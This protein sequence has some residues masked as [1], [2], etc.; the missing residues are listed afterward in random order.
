MKTIAIISRKGGAGKTTIVLHLAVEA[1]AQGKRV[2]VFDLDPQASAALWSDHR[3]T[4]S[5]Y[6]IPAQAPRLA[7][8]LEQ[9]KKQ[10]A[11]LVI[12]DTAPHDDGAASAAASHADFIIIPCRPSSLDLD[13]ITTSIRLASVKAKDAYVLINSAPAQGNETSQAMNA[14]EKAGVQVCPVVLHQR[15]SFSSHMQIGLTAGEFEARGKA[16]EEIRN[17]YSWIANKISI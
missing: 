2:A 17:L 7:S 4:G 9:A 8:M 16:A 3:G 12:I 1:E 6:V 5:P 15:K 10:K 13:A 14:L 11:E